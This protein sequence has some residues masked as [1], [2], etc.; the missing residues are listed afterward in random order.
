MVRRR[1]IYVQDA[2]GSQSHPEDAAVD[3]VMRGLMVPRGLGAQAAS[4]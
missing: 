4:D 2:D 3:W 1:H